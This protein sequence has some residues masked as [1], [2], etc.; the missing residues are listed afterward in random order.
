MELKIDNQVRGT[1]IIYGYQAKQRRT[2]LNKMIQIV[3]EQGFNEIILPSIEKSEIYSNKAGKDI[4]NQMYIFKDKGDRDLCLRP[5]VTATIQLLGDN[6]LKYE[7]DVKLWYF[8]KCW[9]YEKPQK[10]RYREFFQ[11][12]VEIINPSND[13]TKDLIDLGE[14]LISSFVDKYE[15]VNSVKRG[16]NYY[17]EYG[18]EIRVDS[19]GSQKQVLGGGKYKQGNGFAIGFDRLLLLCK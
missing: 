18:F 6:N 15:I 5:E 13:V 8:E 11:F 16:L 2:I 4:L 7:K 17:V 19:L 9:R 14:K 12:G 1:R 3:E 10:G